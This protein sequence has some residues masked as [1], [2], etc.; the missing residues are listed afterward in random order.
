LIDEQS[1]GL[2]PEIARAIG[3]CIERFAA[4]EMAI[5]LIEPIGSAVASCRVLL[6]CHSARST[7]QRPSRVPG[8]RRSRI[9]AAAIF[10]L[11]RV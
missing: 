1:I 4:H 2:A 3:G 10:K 11:P 5:L 7:Q 9:L 8:M 6:E